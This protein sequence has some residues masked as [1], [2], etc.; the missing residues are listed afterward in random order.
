MVF[1][2]TDT[3][4]TPSDFHANEICLFISPLPSIFFPLA[5]FV[6]F[7]LNF[8]AKFSLLGGLLELR[9]AECRGIRNYKRPRIFRGIS[10]TSNIVTLQALELLEGWMEVLEVGNIGGSIVVNGL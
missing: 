9:S 8:L 6:F 10:H 3:T 4:R 1:L 2:Q 5:L 7:K